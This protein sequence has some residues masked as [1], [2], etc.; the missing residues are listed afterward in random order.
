MGE[1]ATN[2]SFRVI[3]GSAH[4][5]KEPANIAIL[6]I[7]LLLFPTFVWWMHRQ[8]QRGKPAIIPNSIWKN[9]AF[10]TS[11]IAV[12]LTWGAFNPLGYFTTLLYD[13]I[14]LCAAR[15]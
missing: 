3:T 14:F 10:T 15:S 4:N 2:D 11:C 8:E 1:M 13:R 6:T 7:A 9:S 5:I 12:F